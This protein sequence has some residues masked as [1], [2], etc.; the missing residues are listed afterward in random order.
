MPSSEA[1]GTPGARTSRRRLRGAVSRQRVLEL[2]DGI[3]ESFGRR[4]RGA[5]KLELPQVVELDRPPVRD[6]EGREP[7]EPLRARDRGRNERH[8]GFERDSR[9]SGMPASLAL[10]EESLPAPGPLRE[11]DDNMPFATELDSRRNRVRVALAAVHRKRPTCGD[12]RPERKPEELR[13]RHKTEVTPRVEREPE[14]PG[15]EIRPVVR[16]EDES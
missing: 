5:R 10:L 16:G 2:L 14:R 1:R 15:I 3:A 11:H 4:C 8:S 12:E 6:A 13:L 7:R 9:R